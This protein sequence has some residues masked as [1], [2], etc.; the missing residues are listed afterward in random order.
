MY[1]GAWHKTGSSI[2]FSATLS[3]QNCPTKQRTVLL[4]ASKSPESFWEFLL[5]EFGTN[6]GTQVRK[7]SSDQA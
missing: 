1:S 6:I 7:P 2:G 4:D 5:M 3:C